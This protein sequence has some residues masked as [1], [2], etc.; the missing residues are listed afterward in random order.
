M[1]VQ[2]FPIDGLAAG[3]G[4]RC[5][6]GLMRTQP[7]LVSMQNQPGLAHLFLKQSNQIQLFIVDAIGCY[8]L[9]L[10]HSFH[11]RW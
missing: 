3:S 6:P 2:L 7:V 9:S 1:Q 4:M 8:W 10:H 11:L 5:W